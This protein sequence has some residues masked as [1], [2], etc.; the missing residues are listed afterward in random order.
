MRCK[1]PLDSSLCPLDKHFLH[2]YGL[3]DSAT[4]TRG[5]LPTRQAIKFLSLLNEMQKSTRQF[6]LCTRIMSTVL[7]NPHL[8]APNQPIRAG[9]VSPACLGL[10][11]D[12]RAKCDYSKPEIGLSTLQFWRNDVFCSGPHVEIQLDRECA[13]KNQRRRNLIWQRSV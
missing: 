1:S 11:M 7:D 9:A 13:F 12:M 6:T 4:I 10:I 3:V 5:L 8:M 2:S